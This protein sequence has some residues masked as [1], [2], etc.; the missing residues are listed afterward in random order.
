MARYDEV[1]RD[2]RER[3][4]TGEYPPGATL[5]KYSDMTTTY[6]VGRGVVSQ[7]IAVLEREGL[8]RPIKRTGIVVLDWTRE[9]RRITRGL[10]V[11]RD[12][13]RGYIFPAASRPDEPWQV[14]GR[15]F[16]EYVPASARIAEIL[17]VDAGLPTLRRRRVTSPEGEVPFQLVDT[18]ISP[19]AVRDAPQVADPSTGPGGYIDRLEEAGHG[20]LAWTEHTRARLP[21]REEARLLEISPE[22]PVFEMALLGTS[23]MTQEVIEVTVRVIPADRVEMVSELKRASSAAW[24]TEPVQPG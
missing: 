5:P 23:A 18:W 2:L 19:T 24:P 14:H 22:M 15:P 3:I 6:G 11:A 12:P 4:H 17:G 16:R 9:R 7:A 13:H 10:L 1:A 8:V 20:P 21:D